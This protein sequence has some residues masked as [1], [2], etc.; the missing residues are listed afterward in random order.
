[1]NALSWLSTLAMLALVIG[2]LPSMKA[3]H[4]NRHDLSAFSLLGASGIFVGQLMFVVYFGYV[5]DWLTTLLE[6][7]LCAFWL[8][9]IIFKVFRSSND[10]TSSK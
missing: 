1:M 2:T 7:P 5:G 6:L 3:M 9:V 8:L 10:S 4:K